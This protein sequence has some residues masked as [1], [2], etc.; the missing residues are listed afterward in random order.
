MTI[1][2]AIITITVFANNDTNN[3]NKDS[4]CLTMTTMIIAVMV[5]HSQ[6]CLT[7]TTMIPTNIMMITTTL[8][9][10]KTLSTATS[11]H[12]SDNDKDND[13]T[14]SSNK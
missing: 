9:S 10:M 6:C 3:D 14:V 5:N 12:D 11:N 2:T 8:P 13:N 7:M 4:C 1:A